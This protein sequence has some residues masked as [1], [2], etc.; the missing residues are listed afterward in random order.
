MN[1]HLYHYFH[2]YCNG[3]TVI[4]SIATFII[5]YQFTKQGTSKSKK[6]P[7]TPAEGA[8]SSTFRIRGGVM[9]PR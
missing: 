7:N 6:D 4:R 2:Y 5:T 3:A 1:Q 8:E 9:T